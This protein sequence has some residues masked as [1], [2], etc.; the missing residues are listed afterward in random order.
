M[1]LKSL[2]AESGL[3]TKKTIGFILGPTGV[4]KTE[5]AKCLAEFLF[6]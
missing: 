5:T 6:R 2:R 3:L 1:R 4:G